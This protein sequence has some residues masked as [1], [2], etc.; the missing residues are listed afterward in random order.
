MMM[1]R[2]CDVPQQPAEQEH[3]RSQLA[4][5]EQRSLPLLP[6]LKE[7]ASQSRRM[8]SH[9]ERLRLSPLFGYLV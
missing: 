1:P 4:A 8:P 6:Y 9:L 2:R 5:E 3:D 7:M